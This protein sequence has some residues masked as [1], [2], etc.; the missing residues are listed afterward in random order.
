MATVLDSPSTLDSSSRS[1]DSATRAVPIDIDDSVSS[2]QI[3]SQLLE[4]QFVFL[5]THG[6]IITVP[7]T[8]ITAVRETIVAMIAGPVDEDLST[9]EAARML[10]VSRPT[11]VRLLDTK[12]IAYQTTDGGHRR[13]SRRAL[14]EYRQRDL[15][16]RRQ[17]LDELAATADEFGFFS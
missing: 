7:E 17:A 16:R 14:A 11:L 15:T 4:D 6:A 1:T 9:Q 5:T 10:G 2:L 13:V 8:V 12:G 3:L